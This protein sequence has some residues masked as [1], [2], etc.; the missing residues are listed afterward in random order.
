MLSGPNR[1]MPPRCAMRFESLRKTREG[2]SCRFFKK[3]PARKVGTR[4]RQCR[5]KVPGRFAFPGALNPRFCS[6]SRFGKIFQQFCWDFPGVFPENPRTDP[7]NSH[8]LLEYSE[9]RSRSGFFSAANLCREFF[10]LVSPGLHSG[11]PKIH[12]QQSDSHLKLSAFSI[13]TSDF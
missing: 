3:H 4:S 7:G 2:W 1:A 5:P 8:S 12:L 11:C 10:G 6:I 9:P 13:P